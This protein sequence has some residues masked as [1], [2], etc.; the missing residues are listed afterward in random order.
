MWAS[1]RI[2]T[3]RPKRVPAAPISGT[4]GSLQDPSACLTLA[5]AAVHAKGALGNLAGE[6]AA[7]V[8]AAV[9]EGDDSRYN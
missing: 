8:A 6:A 3:L 4:A 2:G 5:C 9:E 1:R 7:A